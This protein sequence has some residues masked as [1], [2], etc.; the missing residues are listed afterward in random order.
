[1]AWELKVLPGARRK[2][3]NAATDAKGA[4]L[5]LET[6][7]WYCSIFLWLLL[8]GIGI[9]PCPEEA[10]ILYAA[11]VTALH[12]DVHWW[13]AWPAT[14]AGI[15]CAD[16]VLFAIGRWFGPKLFEYHWVNRIIR[17]DRRRRI[18]NRFQDH[19]MKI[20]LTARFLPPLRTGIFIIAGAIHYPFQRFLAADA[21][22]ALVGVGVFFFGSAGLIELLHRAGHWLVYVVAGAL[23]IYG[24]YRY[25]KHLQKREL[26]VAPPPVSVLELPGETAPTPQGAGSTGLHIS[27]VAQDSSPLSP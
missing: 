24:L 8:T 15:V 7:G 21:A 13:I 4:T 5:S 6:I 22:Y 23:A 17:P 12:P 18:E 27:P 26:K 1:L 3:H 19:G 9:P 14:M 11:G 20:L 2:R 25:Y 16:M 10:G